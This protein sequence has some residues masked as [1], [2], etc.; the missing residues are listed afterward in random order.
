MKFLLFLLFLIFVVQVYGKYTKV[1][2]DLDAIS[3][4]S[5]TVSGRVMFEHGG[6]GK[7]VVFTSKHHFIADNEDLADQLC[8]LLPIP[9]IVDLIANDPF[10]MG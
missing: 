2:D 3:E 6:K 5:S 8:D 7:F 10:F 1:E 9:C 4:Y